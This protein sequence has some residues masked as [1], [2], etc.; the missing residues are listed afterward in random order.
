VHVDPGYPRMDDLHR[1]PP[2]F[3]DTG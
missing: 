2:C 3:P 1:R